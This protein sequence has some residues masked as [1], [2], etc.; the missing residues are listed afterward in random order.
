MGKRSTL[1][2]HPIDRIKSKNPNKNG[3]YQIHRNDITR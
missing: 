2:Q 3:H 1:T